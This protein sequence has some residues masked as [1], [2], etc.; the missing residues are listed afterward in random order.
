[1]ITIARTVKGT[2]EPHVIEDVDASDKLLWR[3][4]LPGAS[5]W[6]RNAHT[7]RALQGQG[8]EGIALLPLAMPSSWMVNA[9]ASSVLMQRWLTQPY[10]DAWIALLDAIGFSMAPEEWLALPSEARES[11]T[12]AI[13]LL[14]EGNERDGAS[15]AA[16]TKILALLRPQIVP[17]MDDAAL[18]FS[19]ELVAEPTT[20]DTPSA[21]AGMFA[22]MLDWFAK[23]TIA[24][25][26]ALIKLAGAHKLAVL[27]AA[28][29]LDRLLWVE[30]WGDRLRRR[31]V[32]E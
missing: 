16:V 18:W 10:V 11:V 3:G 17:L 25:E 14:V 12:T 19:L 1:M 24:N 30:S 5:V 31:V 20:A 6:D 7:L 2:E 8:V 15:V 4:G 22:P 23:Q 29:V 27:D 9:K 28:Q 32:R 21:T 13:A 26:S